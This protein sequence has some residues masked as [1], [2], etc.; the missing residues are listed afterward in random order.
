MD[1]AGMT[2]HNYAFWLNAKYGKSF[3]VAPRFKG[4]TEKVSYEVIRFKSIPL[5]GLNPYRA[6]LPHLDLEF[7]RKLNGSCFDILHAHSP[8]VSG[9]SALHLARKNRIPLVATF[10]S[11]YRLDF[12]KM[13]S[14]KTVVDFLI[15]MMLDFY[16]RVDHVWVPNHSTGNTIREYGYTG[17]FRIMPN[18]TDI[19]IPGDSEQLKLRKEGRDSLGLK[20]SDFVLLFVGQHRWEKNVR[21]IIDSL[22]IIKNQG[23]SFKMVF[24]GEGYAAKEMSELVKKYELTENVIFTG[25][26]AERGKLPGI[27]AGSDLFVFPSIYDNSPLVVIEASA[28]GIP[29]ILV[30]GSSAAENIKD[31]ENGF[32][33]ENSEDALARKIVELKHRPE[34]IRQVGNS[35]RKTIYRSWESIVDEVYKC[36]TEIIRDHKKGRDSSHFMADSG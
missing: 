35:A 20:D 36:Y 19:R 30:N 29:S 27:F 6:G 13:I 2:V 9:R 17:D 24:V 33:I 26:I 11:K 22:H 4:Y 23:K 7:Q 34:L 21:M 25:V 28:F 32:L 8:F 1:G 10:H 31:N 18:G 12:E 15:R 16:G 3:V 5:P 14:N